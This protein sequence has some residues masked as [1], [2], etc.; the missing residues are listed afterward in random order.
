MQIAGFAQ[1]RGACTQ[2]RIRHPLERIN[3]LKLATSHI[4]TVSD[5]NTEPTLKKSDV[6]LLGRAA[7]DHVLQIIKRLQ[8]F[9]KRVVF[10]LDDNMFDVSV[11]SPHYQNL[12]AMQ[13]DF[14]NPDGTK[15]EVWTDGK[16]GF[17]AKRNR[18]IRMSFTRLIRQA[19]CITVTTEPLRKTYSRYNDNVTIIPNAIN[20][21]VWDKLNIGWLGK[22]VRLLYTGAANH[23]EDWL[24]VHPVLEEL[25][26]KYK[27]LT[28]VLIGTDWTSAPNNLDYSRVE[29]HRW[30]DF[31]A[32]PYLLKSLGCHIGIAPISKT[33]FND[34]RSEL[35]WVEY[36][37]LKMATVATPWGPYKRSVKDG[38][39]G[40]LADEREDWVAAL[41][42][43]IED[44]ALRNELAVNAY[45]ECKKNFNLDFAVDLWMKAFQEAKGR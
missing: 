31:E 19:D 30:V 32:Y 10:D 18:Q 1:E 22:E 9:G 4:I 27:N 3:E 2:L 8:M 26:K 41:S 24:F 45:K 6:V 28:I 33:D 15:G 7:S 43:L 16:A 5:A 42:T 38:V 37:A 40:L 29:V 25:Q 17:D 36:S 12:G 11:M 23:F 44:K 14:E 21:R 13:V 35:K 34:C 39:T 20:F